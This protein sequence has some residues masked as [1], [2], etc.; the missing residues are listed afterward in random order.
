MKKLFCSIRKTIGSAFVRK[1]VR[2]RLYD[3]AINEGGVIPCK[4]AEEANEIAEYVNT[5]IWLKKIFVA[6]AY[7]DC[8]GVELVGD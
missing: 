1:C 3:Y 4:S 6:T 8:V 2:E 5:T 7:K